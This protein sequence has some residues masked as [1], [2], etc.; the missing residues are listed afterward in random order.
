MAT[1]GPPTD[2]PLRELGATAPCLQLEAKEGFMPDKT[3]VGAA[4]I[5][6]IVNYWR[7]IE[8][9]CELAVDWS[10]AHEHCWRCGYKSKLEKCHIVPKALGG[11]A[12]AE[13]LVLLCGRCHREA[14]NHQDGRYMWIWLR[15][16]CVPLYNSYWIKRGCDEFK[17]M[18]GREPISWMADLQLSDSDL[19]Q[20]CN[21]MVNAELKRAIVHFG[22][23]RL[24]PSTIACIIAEAEKVIAGRYGATIPNSNYTSST[25]PL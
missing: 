19:A 9:E 8:S 16:T 22:E 11:T 24:N 2:S 25:F 15:A 17:I 23:G 12:S 13:N 3:E 10:D 5:E 18:F 4:T 21:A 6:E 1:V 7:T 14:P 20:E